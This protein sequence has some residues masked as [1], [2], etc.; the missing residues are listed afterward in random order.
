MTNF[1][2]I[3]ISG[4]IQVVSG[5]HIG[6]S[7]A[8]A[9]IGAVDSPVIKDPITHLPIIPGSTI[10]GKMRSLLAEAYNEKIA[11]SPNED[12]EKIV[13][14]FGATTGGG[15]D[16]QQIIPSR[17]LF[18]DAFLTNKEELEAKNVD[19][20]TEVKFENTINRVNAVA[21]P[22]QIER[23]IRGSKF[24]FELI[25]DAR[26]ATQAKEDLQTIKEGIKLLEVDY[27]GGSGSRGYG[28]V[29]FKN[30]EAETVFGKFDVSEFNKELER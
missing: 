1:S 30:L 19:S 15:A 29:E 17:L 25:Y 22:R 24:N 18:R 16:K 14:L 20:V 28:K 10:K 11:T 9:A 27:L 4:N 26:D 2:K 13:R 21:S 6:G 23:V 3:K 8:F 12:H 7:T 5:L